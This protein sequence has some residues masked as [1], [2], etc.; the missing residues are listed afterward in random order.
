MERRGF[1]WAG[2]AAGLMASLPM[3]LRN[4]PLREDVVVPAICDIDP[5]IVKKK[6]DEPKSSF[7]HRE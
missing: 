6:L 3:R 7:C 2:T 1:I 5:E 4:L